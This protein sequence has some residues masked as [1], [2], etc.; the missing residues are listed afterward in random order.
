MVTGVTG[1]L[2]SIRATRFEYKLLIINEMDENQPGCANRSRSFSH[3]MAGRF[4]LLQIMTV[5]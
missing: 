4:F 5:L 3:Q 2:R 1:N